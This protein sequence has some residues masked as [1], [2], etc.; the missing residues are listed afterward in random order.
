SRLARNVACLD[1]SVARGGPL[2]AYR[3]DGESEID[4]SKFVTA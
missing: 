1:W 3:F 4:D 2:V